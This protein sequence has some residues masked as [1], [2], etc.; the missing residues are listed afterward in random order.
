MKKIVLGILTIGFAVLL[1]AC[2]PQRSGNDMSTDSTSFDAVSWQDLEW[3]KTTDILYANQ[4]AIE[5]ADTYGLI[6]IVDSGRFLLVNGD[7]NIP[8]DLPEDVVVIHTP[9][10]NVYLQASAAFDPISKV[11]AL[12]SVTLSGIKQEDMYIEEAYEAMEAGRLLYAGKY[13]APDYE[14]IL[15]TGCDLA[16]ES[17]MIYHNPKVK[18]KL[19]SLGIPV[20]VE[21]SSYES[22]PIGRLEWIKLFG[23]L[24]GKEEEACKFFD[25]QVES[26]QAISDL[27]KTDKTV[28]FF[29]VNS[30]GAINVRKPGD[31]IV[32]LIEMGGGNYALSDILVEEE[33]SL[34]TM[35]IQME[36]FYLYAKN[37]DY[38]IYNS[39]IVGEIGSLEELVEKNPLFAD[40]DA[41]K[42]GQVYC[43][44][45]NFFQETTGMGQLLIDVNKLVTESENDFTYL[46][47]LD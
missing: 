18:E 43:T 35:N 1:G 47:K 24:F 34:S 32:K 3:E 31:Y 12:D 6:T 5:E 10:E 7:D 30:N 26:I 13:S 36:D 8:V 25:Q 21:R 45:R 9:L 27:E 15:T 42:S 22:D 17:T 20:L 40:F 19:E 14:L 4:F 16:L 39:T 37:A 2:G 33:N 38:L 44:E 41:V 28:A 11:G 46:R 29:H 23:F